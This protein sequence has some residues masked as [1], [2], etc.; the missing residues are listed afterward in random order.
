MSIIQ[1][2]LLLEIVGFS[3]VGIFAAI[4]LE[5]SIVG[6]F[7]EKVSGRLRS[8]YNSLEKTYPWPSP[9]G[10]KVAWWVFRFSIILYGMFALVFVG[11]KYHETWAL[12]FGL[13]GI[14]G[15]MIQ[16]LFEVIFGNTSPRRF[17]IG[18][19][20][21]VMIPPLL[22]VTFFIGTIRTLLRRITVEDSL[23][24]YFILIGSLI[25]LLGMILQF[26]ATFS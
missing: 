9:K 23:K 24:K 6:N 7:A 10:F 16:S 19:V 21:L 20:L 17:I 8:T 14:A 18:M 1:T 22:I 12:T 15:F 4:L 11:I 13:T 2:G 3:L 26:I 5:K 25:L